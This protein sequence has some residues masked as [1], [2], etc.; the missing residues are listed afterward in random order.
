VNASSAFNGLNDFGELNVID[1]IHNLEFLPTSRGEAQE[2]VKQ[3][4]D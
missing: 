2:L 1:T 4:N 3:V